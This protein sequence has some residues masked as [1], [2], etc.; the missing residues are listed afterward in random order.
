MALVPFVKLQRRKNLCS[1]TVET[2]VSEEA[3]QLHDERNF[4]DIT[5]SDQQQE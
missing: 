5:V 1:V 4:D 2:K 3:F